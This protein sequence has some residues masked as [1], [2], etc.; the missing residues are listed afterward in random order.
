MNSNLTCTP[1]YNGSAPPPPNQPPPPPPPPGGAVTLT[2]VNPGTGGGGGFVLGPEM[3][4][5]PGETCTF[6][7][8][9]A[10]FV[11]LTPIAYPGFSF[12]GWVGAGCGNAFTLDSSRTCTA[13]FN[14][15]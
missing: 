14:R 6:T 11:T 5:D 13:D 10:T 1:T 12:G 8:T 3:L 7:V 4:C 9:A 15:N 2:I